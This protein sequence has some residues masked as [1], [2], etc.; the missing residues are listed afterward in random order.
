M[1]YLELAQDYL[2]ALNVLCIETTPRVI[3]PIGLLA[4]QAI[5]LSLKAYL[6]YKGLCVNRLRIDIGHDLTKA[7]NAAAHKGLMLP[8]SSLYTVQLLSLSHNRPFR[9]RYPENKVGAAIPCSLD[10][11]KD[12]QAILNIVESEMQ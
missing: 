5:E 2:R 6:V 7:W 11:V 9:F 10:L 12:V 1:E 4:S 8:N 3:E